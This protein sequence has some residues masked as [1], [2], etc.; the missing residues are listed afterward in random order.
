[1]FPISVE[2]SNLV[3]DKFDTHRQGQK[4]LKAGLNEL[5]ISLSMQGGLRDWREKTWCFEG[6]CIS[7]SFFFVGLRKRGVGDKKW[8]GNVQFWSLNLKILKIY[9][10]EKSDLIFS[11]LVGIFL[12]PFYNNNISGA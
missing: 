2:S 3:G 9:H 7:F 4:A 5:R 1:M 11:P 8:R 6:N 12:L 10:A